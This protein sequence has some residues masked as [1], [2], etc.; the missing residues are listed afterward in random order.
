MR[1]ITDHLKKALSKYVC[2]PK[3]FGLEDIN[4]VVARIEFQL[5]SGLDK[6][7]V[8]ELAKKG[9]STPTDLK[10]QF[11]NLAINVSNDLARITNG[12]SLVECTGVNPVRYKVSECIDFCIF[13]EEEEMKIKG[14]TSY[15]LPSS[16]NKDTHG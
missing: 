6:Q 10:L 7:I 13:E 5:L 12:T 1:N 14:I 9:E 15:T 16:F 11:S 8:V 3:S 2:F 4:T